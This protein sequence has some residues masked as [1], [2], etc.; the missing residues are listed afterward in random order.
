MKIII[1]FLCL[2]PGEVQHFAIEKLFYFED[3]MSKFTIMQKIPKQFI[4][5]LD[6]IL[7]VEK[8]KI[9]NFVSYMKMRP[10]S[11]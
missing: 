2:V 9:L 10:R 6:K 5:F 3:F 7:F 1:N 8:M 11:K 4:I